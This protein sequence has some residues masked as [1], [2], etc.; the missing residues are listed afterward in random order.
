LQIITRSHPRCDDTD[1]L[2]T[3]GQRVRYR[4]RGDGPPILMIHG[5]GAPLEF[6]RPLEERLEGY[7][8]IT[9]DPPGAGRSST[10]RGRFTMRDFAGVLEDVV[11]HLEL[12]SVSVVGLSLG[13]L[14][15]Q[16]F[17][18]R[19][20][21]QVDRLVLASTTWG[22]GSVPAHPKALAAV[23]NPRRSSSERGYEEVA[24][25]IYGD[26][27]RTDPALLQEHMEIRSRTKPSLRGH[28]VQLRATL[29]WTSVPWLRTLRVPI[30]VI[31]G[32]DDRIVPVVNARLLASMARDARLEIIQ[33]GSHL[34]AIQ[35]PE[36]TSGLIKDFLETP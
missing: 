17:A 32:S 21:R 3:R 35:E 36:K 9:L 23:A 27:V 14:M 18:H 24:P 10:P 16:E 20:P 26:Q 1:F 34:C 7:Q 29:T 5:I 30:L 15:A 8:T 33:G 25:I 4:V 11:A 19:S 6:W 13:G 22:I 28:Y 12:D 31:A 2:E